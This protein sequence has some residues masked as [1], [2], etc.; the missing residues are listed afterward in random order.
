MH[1]LKSSEQYVYLPCFSQQHACLLSQLI[2]E[3][4]LRR[5][6]KNYESMCK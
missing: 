3:I 2:L 4:L 1:T 5:S 6:P